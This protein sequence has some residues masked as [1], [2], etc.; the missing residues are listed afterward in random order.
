MS[1]A[2]QKFAGVLAYVKIFKAAAG[3]ICRKDLRLALCEQI[4][5]EYGISKPNGIESLPTSKRKSHDIATLLTAKDRYIQRLLTENEQM[6]YEVE[7]FS[8]KNLSSHA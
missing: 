4:L 5:V 1:D 6:K 8:R 7:L 2:R 3:I